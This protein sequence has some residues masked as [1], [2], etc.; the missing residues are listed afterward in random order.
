MKNY[1]SKLDLFDFIIKKCSICYFKS[2]YAPESFL[3][4]QH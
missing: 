3:T 1:I 4:N 2:Q